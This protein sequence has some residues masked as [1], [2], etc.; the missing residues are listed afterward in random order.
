[1]VDP[2]SSEMGRRTRRSM[3]AAAA[4][5][6]ALPFLASAHQHCHFD[7]RNPVVGFESEVGFCS[8]EDPDGCCCDTDEEMSV[9]TRYESASVSGDCAALHQEVRRS[10]TAVYTFRS[11]VAEQKI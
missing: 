9:R 5:M 2:C 6:V 4:T 11:A 8:N 7:A 1:M 10:R 3:L